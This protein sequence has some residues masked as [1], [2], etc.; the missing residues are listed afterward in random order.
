ML[1]KKEIGGISSAQTEQ[2]CARI[3]QTRYT[4]TSQMSLNYFMQQEAEQKQVNLNA[5]SLPMT[6]RFPRSAPYLELI[7]FKILDENAPSIDRVDTKYGYVPGNIAVIS[8]RAN[9]RKSDASINEI[10]AILAYFIEQK[11]GNYKY[12][13]TRI[14]YAE[15]NLKE[16]IDI[17][18]EY[19]NGLE[20]DVNKD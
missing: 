14:P 17:F 1:H 11:T 8:K 3:A 16:L 9:S 20:S 2:M 6:S 15:R 10:F 5:V 12:E 7:F 18:I 13:N 19:A 4:K